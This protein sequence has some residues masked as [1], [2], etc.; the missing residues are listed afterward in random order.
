MDNS[1]TTA[2][3]QTESVIGERTSCE[4]T[5]MLDF[6]KEEKISKQAIDRSKKRRCF[7][8]Q[9]HIEVKDMGRRTSVCAGTERFHVSVHTSLLYWRGPVRIRCFCT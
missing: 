4:T 8:R 1:S 9:T 2:P 6:V 7:M 5:P 3:A